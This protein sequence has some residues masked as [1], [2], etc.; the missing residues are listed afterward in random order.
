MV[1]VIGILFIGVITLF[2]RNTA[3]AETNGGMQPWAYLPMVVKPLGDVLFGPVHSGE[4]T[5]YWEADGTGNCLFDETDNLMIA[6]MNQYDYGTADLCGAYI[7]ATGPK[8]SVIVRIVDQC[9]NCDD[10][11]V[12]FS[13]EA[14]AVIADIPQGRVPITWQLISPEITTPIEY[15]FD[16]GGHQWWTAVQVR[17]I[18]NPVTKF[19][20]WDGASWVNVERVEWNMFIEANGMGP[21]PYTFRVTDY[22][23]NTLVDSNIPLTIGGTVAGSSQFPPP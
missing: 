23:G 4:G 16:P 2:N 21:G 14:F 8:G 6:A 17:N 13:P 18:R 22:F 3:V 10:E 11:Q 5:Y 7:Q 12:D 1:A 20:Y 19:E 9:A 15:Y